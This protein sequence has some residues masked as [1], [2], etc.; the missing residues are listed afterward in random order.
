MIRGR[1]IK[2][3]FVMLFVMSAVPVDSRGT[4][5]GIAKERRRY[6]F[7]AAKEL[8]GRANDLRKV[9]A[10]RRAACELLKRVPSELP[11]SGCH[12]L[13]ALTNADQAI[14]SALGTLKSARLQMKANDFDSSERYLSAALKSLSEAR[15]Q[16]IADSDD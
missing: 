4:N 3:I 9:V 1:Y 14:S 10:H 6:L 5:S 2:A 16:L 13:R 12:G 11:D 8:N 15:Q 7:T